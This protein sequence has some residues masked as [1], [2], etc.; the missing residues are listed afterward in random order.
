MGLIKKLVNLSFSNN[1]DPNNYQIQKWIIRNGQ[2]YN[3]VITE[4]TENTM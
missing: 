2:L 1:F 3:L 4:L